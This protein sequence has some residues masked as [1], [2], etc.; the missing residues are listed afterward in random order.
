MFFTRIP[1]PRSTKWSPTILERSS[2]W[3]SSVGIL[4][5]LIGATSAYVSLRI[6][7]PLVAAILSTLV[8]VLATGA[9][10]EDG[11][12]DTCDAMFGASDRVRVLEIMKDS[13][14]GSFGAAG[15]ILVLLAK[16]STL[17]NILSIEPV[18][19]DRFQTSA[20]GAASIAIPVAHSFSRL[21]ST[22]L[23]RMLTYIRE[24]DDVGAKS[25]PMAKQISLQRLGLATGIT[26]GFT[27]IFVAPTYLL[28][29]C[30]ATI[31]TTLAMGL[32][33]RQRIGG[34]TG[35]CLGATQ[36]VVEVAVLLVLAANWN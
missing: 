35:D 3:F 15:L 8:T 11:L 14:V 21:A 32:W 13:R 6:F 7:D 1:V 2:T 19:W 25:K 22:G 27:A 16:V 31:M 34:Y 4:V 33:F 9:F 30:A 24:N 28:S 18:T 17:S 10:H 26:V 5:G 20:I 12:A 36:Q 23:L 29:I